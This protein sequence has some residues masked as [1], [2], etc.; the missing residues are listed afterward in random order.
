MKILSLKT[1]NMKKC[2]I[3]F[4]GMVILLTMNMSAQDYSKLKEIKLSDSLSCSIA[5]KQ[6]IECCDYLLTTPCSENI[7]ALHAM[8]FIIEWMGATPDY[9][10][11]FEN[12]VY[13]AVKSDMYLTGRYYASLAKTAIANNYRTNCIDLQCKAVTTL[14]E[15]C[16]KPNN[17]I[18]ITSKIQKYLD[19]KSNNTLKELLV[20]E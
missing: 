9:T 8:Q 4:A 19:A 17:K 2:R 11:S 14:L 7:P 16:E 12:N 6:V 18:Q 20:I 10:F 1:N 15:Y 13:K 3:L 5:Q